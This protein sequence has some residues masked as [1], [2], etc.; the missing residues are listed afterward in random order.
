MELVPLISSC[1][2]SRTNI[3]VDYTELNGNKVLF[4]SSGEIYELLSVIRKSL[5]GII[6][7]A[8]SLMRS[9]RESVYTRSSRK[10]AIKIF[11]RELLNMNT[12]ETWTNPM[13]EIASVQYLNGEHSSRILKQIECC[14]YEKNIYWIT[15]F[16]EGDDLFEH[17]VK[18]GRIEDREAQWIIGEVV[19]SIQYIHSKGIAHRDVSLENIMYHPQSRTVTLVDFGLCTLVRRN[20]S[21][22]RNIRQAAI[23]FGKEHYMAPE[24]FSMDEV[25]PMLCDVWAVGVCLLYLLLGFPPIG[26]ANVRDDRY[27]YIT[28]GRLAELLGHWKVPLSKSAINLVENILQPN[29]MDRCSLADILNH[30]WFEEPQTSAGSLV[31]MS[32]FAPAQSNELCITQMFESSNVLTT[33]DV[34]ATTA[35]RPS[36]STSSTG[37]T[38]LASIFSLINPSSMRPAQL[39]NEDTF[40]SRHT[41]RIHSFRSAGSDAMDNE[42]ARKLTKHSHDNRGI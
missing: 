11:S 26:T 7:S 14:S 32:Y 35:E 3:V 9:N 18:Y 41:D 38:P 21:T 40:C 22:G 10:V 33:T 39:N 20:E 27:T 42:R 13:Y 36:S 17:L 1:Q 29:P 28:N 24:Y 37:N 15:N 8:V 5:F 19:R 16:Y 23:D 2:L 6:V 4:T 12:Y 25:D 31:P 34:G 30:P